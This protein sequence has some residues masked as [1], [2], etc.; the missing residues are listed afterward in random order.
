MILLAGQLEKHLAHKNRVSMVMCLQWDAHCLHI[1]WP[2]PL[3]SRNPIIS[4]LV[5]IQKDFAFLVPPYP[6]EPE[7]DTMVVVTQ[8][9]EWPS[10]NQRT[11]PCA[12]V[13]ALP[14]APSLWLVVL[15]LLPS[16]SPAVL[17]PAAVSAPDAA[18]L[19]AP[20]PPPSP[21]PASSENQSCIISARSI[22][23]TSVS[24]SLYLQC[25][26]AVGWAA[27]RASGL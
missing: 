14:H 22:N 17:P 6:G 10:I 8:L 23:T 19:P 9:K 24:Q 3:P 7:K 20:P 27:R 26:D 4:C 21:Q 15:H 5:K 16:V 12:C 11:V 18:A 13:V 25:F 2:M 1:V